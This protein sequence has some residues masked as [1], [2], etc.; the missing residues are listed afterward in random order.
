MII[1]E[2]SYSNWVLEKTAA[3]TLTLYHGSSGSAHWIS[4]FDVAWDNLMLVIWNS[5]SKFQA[6][7]RI[8]DPDCRALPCLTSLQLNYKHH[9]TITT[10]S[11]NSSPIFC[12]KFR[13]QRKSTKSGARS[14][15]GSKGI[16]GNTKLPVLSYIPKKDISCILCIG[17]T[18]LTRRNI[19]C[20]PSV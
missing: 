9:A 7:L 10:N 15:S 8:A 12:L 13:C 17:A 6:L 16:L 18:S 5:S 14:S 20:L 4:S 19:N 2:S 3:S 1:D 11:N